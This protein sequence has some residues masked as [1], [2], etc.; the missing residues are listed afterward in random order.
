M[1]P[2]QY[3]LS[4]YESP[5]SNIIKNYSK[6]ELM[7]LKNNLSYLGLCFLDLTFYCRQV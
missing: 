5:N 7:I 1:W 3:F 6:L 2:R 4:K